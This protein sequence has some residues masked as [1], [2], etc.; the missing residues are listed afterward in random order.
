MIAGAIVK[1]AIGNITFSHEGDF[2]NV[3]KFFN[4]LLNKEYLNILAEYGE[5]GVEALREMTPKDTGLTANSWYYVIEHN[6]RKSAIEFR[7]SNIQ[8][9]TNIALIIQY[10]HATGRGTYVQGRDYINPALKPVF[11]Q[12]AEEM[13]KEVCDL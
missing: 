3:E 13:W 1:T 10:G 6:A 12:L 4:K 5:K 8:E 7:N 11:D 9:G 2:N